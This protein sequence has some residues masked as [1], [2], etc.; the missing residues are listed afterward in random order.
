MEASG[1]RIPF[2]EVFFDLVRWLVLPLLVGQLLRPWLGAMIQRQ[3]R[4]ATKV[5]RT[6]I[7]L[8][9]YTS[10]C[11]SVKQGIWTNYGWGNVAMLT[12]VSLILF[13]VVIV[14]T[15]AVSRILKFPREEEIVVM[16]CGSQKTLAAGIPMAQ[17]IF[18]GHPAMGLI[19]LPIMIYHPLQLI[20]CSGLAS[21]WARRAN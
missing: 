20:L 3:K 4:W 1:L 14:V 18:A 7:L 5:D 21:R 13:V 16:F 17:L 9:V 15:R 8:L 19:L 11:E 10:F 12:L 2:G 6:V